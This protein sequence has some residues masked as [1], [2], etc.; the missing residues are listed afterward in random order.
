[1]GVNADDL[2]AEI[3]IPLLQCLDVCLKRLPTRIGVSRESEQ[4]ELRPKSLRKSLSHP[5]LG[6]L[7]HVLTHR[8]SP[9]AATFC[10]VTSSDFLYASLSAPHGLDLPLPALV[11]GISEP[12]YDY[13]FKPGRKWLK[14]AHQSGGVSCNQWRIIG[15]VLTLSPEAEKGAKRLASRFYNSNIY[16]SQITLDQ[17]NS[18]RAALKELLGVDCNESYGSF[19]EGIY[20]IDLAPETIEQLTDERLPFDEHGLLH[21]LIEWED[22]RELFRAWP[23]FSLFLIAANSD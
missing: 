18:Y 20:P 15:S 4:A 12:G 14:I 8:Y 17:L 1:M 3:E 21:G 10:T 2:Q 23:H 19:E 13:R 9:S 22:E 11:L 5:Y 16:R 6:S 7:R